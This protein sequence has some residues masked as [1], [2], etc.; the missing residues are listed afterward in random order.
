MKRMRQVVGQ[1]FFEMFMKAT[2][3]GQFVAGEDQTTIKP[4]I[5]RYLCLIPPILTLR[6]D[7]L[8]KKSGNGPSRGWYL[9][10]PLR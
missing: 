7:D 10:V 5:E 6:G 1:R 8:L 9:S 2:F 3:Y 4:T